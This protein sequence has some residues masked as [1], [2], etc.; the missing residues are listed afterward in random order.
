MEIKRIS[1]QQTLEI[2]Q[3]VLWPN[4]SALSSKIKDDEI[5]NHYGVFINNKLVCVASIFIKNTTARLRK[6]ATL[7]E[8]QGQGIGSKLLHHIIEQLTKHN[9]TVFWCDARK[10]AV[11][12]YQK[13]NMNIEGNEFMKSGMPYFRMSVNLT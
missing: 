1:W 11:G 5:A 7:T 4:K 9:V 3:K 2:R 10:T 12:I 8:Y 13:F 6:F